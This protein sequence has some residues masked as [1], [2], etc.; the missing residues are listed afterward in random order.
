MHMLL[1]E[2]VP[3]TACQV[4]ALCYFAVWTE[5]ASLLPTFL[6]VQVDARY[7]CKVSV[8]LGLTPA[9]G[10]T[11]HVCAAAAALC[12]ALRYATPFPTSLAVRS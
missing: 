4:L 6:C 1:F 2:H 9:C 5:L 3:S 12:N 11:D 7:G 10:A 8:C